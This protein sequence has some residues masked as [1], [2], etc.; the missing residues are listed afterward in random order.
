MRS[1]SPVDAG[2]IRVSVTLRR[3]G[4][5][6][7]EINILVQ[8][9]GFVGEEPEPLASTLAQSRAPQGTGGTRRSWNDHIRGVRGWAALTYEYLCFPSQSPGH[10]RHTDSWYGQG[11]HGLGSVQ[12]GC[13]CQEVGVR[14]DPRLA[15][16][17]GDACAWTRDMWRHYKA[18]WHRRREWQR[19]VTPTTNT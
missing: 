19:L 9:T 17:E 12:S 16:S 2:L 4:S 15:R 14:S 11:Q 5:S 3:R 1:R 13:V 7:V 8:E 10:Q 18:T 6:R